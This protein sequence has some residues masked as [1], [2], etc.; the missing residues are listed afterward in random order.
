MKSCKYIHEVQRKAL[1]D[2]FGEIKNLV[3][4]D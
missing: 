1:K 2:G 4:E 3:L